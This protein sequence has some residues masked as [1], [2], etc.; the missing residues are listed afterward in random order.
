M[1]KENSEEYK[2]GR[3]EMSLSFGLRQN[4]EGMHRE[5]LPPGLRPR[6]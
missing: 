4:K 2:K 6:P 1:G 3:Y 5:N